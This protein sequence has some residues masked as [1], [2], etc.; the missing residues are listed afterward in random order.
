MKNLKKIKMFIAV[1]AV[2][3]IMTACGGTTSQS[4]SSDLGSSF[5]LPD[6]HIA[7][8][9][10]ASATSPVITATAS[11]AQIL[12]AKAAVSGAVVVNWDSGTP[13]YEIFNLLRE[14]EYPRDEGVIDVSNIYKLLFEAGNNYS[15]AE[16]EVEE[17]IE[18]LEMLPPFDFGNDP[19][20]FTHAADSDALVV[21][22]GR[23]EAILTWI[24]NETPTM[25]YGVLEGSYNEETGDIVLDMVYIV[26][27][28]GDND[29]CLRMHIS[30]NENTHEFTL[31]AAKRGSADDSFAMSIIGSGVSMS[32]N[33]E[34]YFLIKMIDNGQLSEFADGRYFKV[35]S[36]ATESDLMEL[37]PEG[38]GLSEIDD[39]DGHADVIE[40][41]DFIPLDGSEHA[42]S[43]DDFD[44]VELNLVR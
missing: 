23:I 33:E 41:M 43:V 26:D 32:D 12:R 42:L 29:Y 25:S 39:P 8:Y 13:T 24:W 17:L 27:Y 4:S 35:S 36:S 16:A 2:S 7:F 1:L 15:N 14:Y 40:T 20:I 22:D 30:G 11:P 34:D 19:V 6:D 38:Q 31:K 18:P 28:E 3:L 9:T 10:S 5:E 21:V 44:N 37:D